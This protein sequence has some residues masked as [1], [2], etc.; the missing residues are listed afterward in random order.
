MKKWVTMLLAAL[1]LMV[2]AIPALA[3]TMYT[4]KSTKAYDLPDT[5]SS[6]VKK[7]KAAKPVD[8]WGYDDG[9]YSTQYGYIQSSYL[10]DTIPQSRCSHEWGPW[11]IERE[12]TC[13]QNGYKYRFCQI[14]GL[15]DEREIKKTGHDWGKWKVTK[16]ATC[17]KKGTRTRTCKICGAEETESYY[18]DHQYG[19]WKVTRQPT[20][21]EVGRRVRTCQ[22]CGEQDS[23]AI[24][25]LPH[26]YE[27]EIVTPATD[28]S[29]GLRRKICRVCGH[30]GGTETFDPEGTLHRGDRGD[31]VRA[32]QQL[33]ADQNYLNAGG[34]DG[35]FG[36]GTEKAVIQ[37]QKDQGLTP[38]G[39]GWPQTQKRLNHEFGPWEIVKPMTRT[40]PGERVRTCVEC[41][42]QQRETIE[43]GTVLEKGRRGE[44]I[45]ALQQIV[46]ELG[47]D[48][49]SFDGIYG[50][51]L[52]QAM[53][54]FAA[55]HGFTVEEGKIRPADVD[56]VMR[57]WISQIPDDQWM[58][59][60]SADTAV[61]LA[62][63][64]TAM[65]EDD[66]SDVK[67]YVWNLTNMGS[68]KCM[69]NALLLTF[70]ENADF[71]GETMT[72][73]IDGQE[74]KANAQN[75]LSGSFMAAKS[76]GEGDMHFA[77]LGVDDKTGEKWLSND[78]IFSNPA[79]Y[80]Q[81]TVSPQAEPLNVYALPE[82][83]YPVRF[84]AGDIFE[85]ASGL[86]MNAVHIFTTDVYDLVEMN[87]LNIGDTLIVS[88]EPLTVDSLQKREDTISVNGGR[89]SVE[90]FTF[91]PLENAAG[92]RVSLLDG[93]GTYTERG[94][95]TL[96][97]NPEATLQL[98]G[99][100]IAYDDIVATLAS[101]PA[102]SFNPW[103]T[104]VWIADGQVVQIVV[105]Q[106]E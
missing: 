18:A 47:Y 50:R 23:Q 43:S 77:A 68:Q 106:A 44:D 57:A 96:T 103:N 66:S 10:S 8:V 76:W 16:K 86:F 14:C 48:A 17:V 88:Q 31:A 39:I 36:G 64:V 45:R 89:D 1:L 29:S 60:G 78:V 75:S 102:H 74:M 101:Q 20:C 38:D 83:E 94:I 11:T 21:T 12:A 53:A 72:M 25:K 59:E 104:R 27:W 5:S 63:T 15:R 70:G 80:A 2:L 95:T 30:D 52:D 22:V 42:Y 90:G 49:G 7:L 82:G 51:K 34:V 84:D 6:V 71:K 91:V 9:W 33:L 81:K 73:V 69:F 46:K 99:Q 93:S 58:G 32:F 92:Y 19:K 100:T 35:M 87:T 3:D 40:E 98:N 55:D 4:L 26:E 105:D 41:G 62:L 61:D 56:E 97:V 28:H 85:G 65:D 13:T 54:G 37:F 67:T 24:E 79:I